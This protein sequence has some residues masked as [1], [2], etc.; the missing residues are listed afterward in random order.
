MVILFLTA[1]FVGHAFS[2]APVAD[3]WVRVQSDDREFSIEVPARSIFCVDKDGFS[4]AKNSEN[5]G[6]KDMKML[7]SFDGVNLLSFEIYN[8]THRALDVMYGEDIN[9]KSDVTAS[10]IKRQGYSIK[11]FIQKTDKF[12]LIRR[13][14][15]SKNNIYILTAGS[16]MGETESMRRFLDSMVFDPV[17]PSAALPGA[18]SLSSLK[19]TGVTVDFDLNR[20]LPKTPVKLGPDP[21]TLPKDDTLKP[22][23]IFV[24]PHADYVDAARMK[25]VAGTIL[26]LA[27][28]T[29]DGFV[30]KMV[31]EKALPE[32]LLRQAIFAVMRLKYFPQEKDGK[33]ESVDRR[34]EYTFSIY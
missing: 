33:P 32:G 13:Y 11:E 4:I 27:S 5:F 34:I 16:R 31:I 20:K 22:L 10:E 23:T 28:F 21:K 25:A 7:N 30:K 2:Q 15:Y 14:F 17:S 3:G 8:A 18:R 6:L 12:Y 1:I 29:S 19:A 26:L 24:K 9:N